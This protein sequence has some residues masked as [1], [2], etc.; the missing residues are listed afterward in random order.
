MGKKKLQ[1]NRNV[2]IVLSRYPEP[3]FTKTR[4]YPLLSPEESARLSRSFIQDTDLALGRL[5]HVDKLWCYYPATGQAKRFFEKSLRFCDGLFPQ[6]GENFS[7]RLFNSLNL[8]F[9][10]GYKRVAHMGTDSPDVPL[11]W[12]SSLFKK[13]DD[14]DIVIGPALDGGYYLLGVRDIY[15]TL[16]D[17]M[18]VGTDLVLD[19]ILK[20]AAES[21]LSID[22]LGFYQ[23]IDRA[24]DFFDFAHRMWNVYNPYTFPL[25]QLWHKKK[26]FSLAS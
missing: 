16:F 19:H 24:R 12:I 25:I 7:Q 9:E 3:G 14:R 21:G 6:E 11:V 5:S 4:L 26:R 2:V 1:K 10:R 8:G 23:D 13:L 18:P 17:Q 20:R 22:L 15:W